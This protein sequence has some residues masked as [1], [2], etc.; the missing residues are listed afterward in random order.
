MRIIVC[1]KQIAHTYARTGKDAAANFLSDTDSV[2]RINPPDEQAMGIA[3][4]VS[5]RIHLLTLGPLVAET[6]LRRLV[7]LGADALYH[8]DMAPPLDPWQKADLLARS[9][10]KIGA[11]LVLMGRESL[12]TRNG[13]TGALLSAALN[14]PF[15]SGI[16][17]VHKI[18]GNSHIEVERVAGRGRRERIHA[19]LP[20][21]CTVDAAN[22]SLPVPTWEALKKSRSLP[23]RKLF[24]DENSPASRRVRIHLGPPRPRAKAPAPPNSHLSSHDRIKQLLTGSRTEKKGEMLSGSLANQMDGIVSFL[25][26]NDF[27]DSPKQKTRD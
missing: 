24:F 16:R 18:S 23:I 17:R 25:Q 11:D 27:L 22:L 26:S 12:D 6:E 21:V 13:Q 3:L 7:A 4:S 2:F 5:A 9:V 15:V 1:V 19:P 8:L 10:T 14:R 20:A